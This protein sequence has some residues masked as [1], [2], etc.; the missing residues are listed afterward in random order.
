MEAVVSDVGSTLLLAKIF[1]SGW[2]TDRCG[3][4]YLTGWGEEQRTA[5][6]I[7]GVVDEKTASPE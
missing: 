6:V 7:F 1:G 5:K 2:R 3:T 4:A